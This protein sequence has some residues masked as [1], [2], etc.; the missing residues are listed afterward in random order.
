MKRMHRSSSRRCRVTP[1]EVAGALHRR[2]DGRAPWCGRPQRTQLPSYTEPAGF[3][4]GAFCVLDE[5]F[6]VEGFAV[7][8][9]RAGGDRLM[10]KKKRTEA[11]RRLREGY[12]EDAEYDFAWP[13]DY[14]YDADPQYPGGSL[15]PRGA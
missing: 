11:N 15:F 5:V 10:A 14:P 13:A 7:P 1:A 9:R 3:V 2:G 8:Q 12:P 6:M 4:A